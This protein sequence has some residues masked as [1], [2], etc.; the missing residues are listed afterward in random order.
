MSFTSTL[1]RA[2][3]FRASVMVASVLD[4][5]PPLLTFNAFASSSPILF[6]RRQR[7]H[8][9]NERQRSAHHSEEAPLALPTGSVKQV[10]YL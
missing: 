1:D 7:R 6:V 8:C 5:N 3:V 4:E 2:A 10:F 9:A